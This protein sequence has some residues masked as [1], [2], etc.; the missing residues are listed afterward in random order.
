[1]AT[2]EPAAPGVPS[3]PGRERTDRDSNLP[4]DRVE[5]RR[6]ADRAIVFEN[7]VLRRAWAIYYAV[8]AASFAVFFVFP[9]VVSAVAPS[10]SPGQELIYNGFIAVVVLLTIWA[11]SWTFTQTYRAARFL[12]AR[13]SR[14]HAR[15]RFYLVLAVGLAIFGAI[16]AASFANAHFGL[17]LEDAALGALNL[18]LLLDV[19]RNFSRAPPETWIAVGTYLVSLI[20]SATALLASGSQSAFGGWWIVAIAGWVFS[21]VYA[22]YHAPEEYAV[23]ADE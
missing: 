18:W 16:L 3:L 10:V 20:G 23:G 21:S 2:E 11:T 14:R 22:L 12:E 8:W 5:L 15:R 17:L 1:M 19:R 6:L 13:E 7:Y 4:E 9:A